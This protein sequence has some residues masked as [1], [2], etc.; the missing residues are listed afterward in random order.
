MPLIMP[1]FA[2]FDDK[3]IAVGPSAPPIIP[4]A[5]ASGILKPRYSAPMNV[6][7]MPTCAAAP[8]NIRR[9]FDINEEKSVIAPIP[10][11]ING[12]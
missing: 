12:G 8:S 5:P 9:G 3:K 4:I 11:N 10:R 7:N 2:S 1:P 6:K